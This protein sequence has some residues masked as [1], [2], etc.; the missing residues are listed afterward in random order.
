[1]TLLSLD[2]GGSDQLKLF[3]LD[4]A[5]IYILDSDLRIRYCNPAWDQFALA[6]NGASLTG[7]NVL[8]SSWPEAIPLSLRDFYLGAVARV[9]ESG[10]PWEHDFDCPSPNVER[11][12]HMRIA[13]LEAGVARSP[14]L[15]ANS[16]IAETPHSGPLEDPDPARFR[17]EDGMIVMCCHCRRTQCPDHTG[18]WLWVPGFLQDLPARVSHGLC[19]LCLQL[20]YSAQ[21]R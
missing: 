6:N 9:W 7:P 8:G 17:Q 11:R 19:A 15:V 21:L 5:V 10:Q 12:F 3:D 4:P 13:P 14:L 16:L 1:M 18:T 2:P 20:H